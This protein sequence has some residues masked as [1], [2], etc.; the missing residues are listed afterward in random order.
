MT[1]RL[2]NLIPLPMIGLPVEGSAIWEADSFTF[3]QGKK[4]LVEAASGKGKTSLLSIMYGLRKDYRG[5]LLI[6]GTDARKLNDKAWSRIRKSRA[7]YIFQGL[8][9]FDDLS[10]MDNILLKNRIT[11]FRS[12]NQIVEMAEKLDMAPFLN[13]KCRLLSFG[14][15]QRVAI[16]R[17]LCQPFEFLFADECFSHIDRNNSAVAMQLITEVCDEQG[18]GLILTSL[19]NNQQAFN[20]HIRI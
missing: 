20:E 7:S 14:Q 11:K 9:L 1:F 16:I 18:A 5:T 13:R 10:A 8:E 12:Q 3:S 2:E 4:Y 15:Q 17:S 6:D 19:G